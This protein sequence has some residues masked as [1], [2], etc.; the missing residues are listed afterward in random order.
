MLSDSSCSHTC[1]TVNV[2]G[3]ELVALIING[4]D[5]S[6]YFSEGV[7]FVTTIQ[8]HF[9]FRWTMLVALS[10]LR[11]PGR[12]CP[13]PPQCQKD[14][15]PV[16]A[17][18]CAVTL[19]LPGSGACL[20]MGCCPQGGFGHQMGGHDLGGDSLLVVAT[21]LE[22]PLCPQAAVPARDR[23]MHGGKLKAARGGCCSAHFWGVAG[24]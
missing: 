1:S 22:A 14:P 6:V 24:R 12:L 7:I 15:F 4:F 11:M 8:T 23:K 20:R 10:M 18:A 19:L 2:Q 13:Y 3:G 17:R 9:Q 21:F 16:T 5:I